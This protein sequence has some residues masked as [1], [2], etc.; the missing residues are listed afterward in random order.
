M[1]N[2]SE[3]FEKSQ[4][5]ISLG[6]YNLVIKFSQ[7]AL[8]IEPNNV[9]AYYNLALA[10]L[11]LKNYDKAVEFIK[12][13]ISIEPNWDDCLVLY[14]VIL[15][16]KE[17]YEPALKKADEA[18]KIS[19][20]NEIAMYLKACIFNNLK[21]NKE[22]EWYI[23]KALEISPNTSLYHL[24]L[25]EIY[26]DTNRNKLAEQEYL[27]A[28]RLEPNNSTF[29]NSYG[30]YLLTKN[31]GS[32]KGLELL[33]ASLRINPDNRDVIESYEA[34]HTYQNLFFILMK[35]YKEI[36]EQYL[37]KKDFV[38]IGIITTILYFLD[39]ESF[40]KFYACFLP[41]VVLYLIAFIYT[42]KNIS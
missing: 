23:K 29:L 18:L 10:Y 16:K 17:Q 1:S 19:P 6:K 36:W 34:F 14:C 15:I 4:V 3:L 35:A 38:L 31:W 22:A 13:A 11:Y 32:K 27:E 26:S 28:L 9:V 42:K 2:L 25:A 39:I 41:F 33:K 40:I 8:S 5:A 24:K 7:E 30:M 20:N 37:S 12:L 21:S